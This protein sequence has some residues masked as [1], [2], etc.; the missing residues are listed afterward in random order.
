MS[1][2]VHELACFLLDALSLHV[3]GLLTERHHTSALEGLKKGEM[4][5]GVLVMDE[6]PRVP[7]PHC[8]SR[9]VALPA[10]TETWRSPQ[11]ATRGTRHLCRSWEDVQRKH[12]LSAIP[13]LPPQRKR[14]GLVS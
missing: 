10:N 8:W 6:E 7:H 11:G 4:V 13:D 1:P 3:P 5:V 12:L 14:R 2:H 9:T